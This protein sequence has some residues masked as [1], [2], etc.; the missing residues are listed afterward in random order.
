VQDEVAGEVVQRLAADL[1][2]PDGR[3]SAS[4][5]H[6]ASPENFRKY[7][8]RRS[9]MR[10]RTAPALER[11]AGLFAEVMRDDPDYAPAIAGFALA[12]LIRP[13]Y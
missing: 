13:S 11:A 4:V 6:Q 12:Q 8:L 2:A 5:N 10:E 9:L 1:G 7:L 3:A